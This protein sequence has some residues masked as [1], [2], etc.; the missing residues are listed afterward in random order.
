MSQTPSVHT[1]C[2]RALSLVIGRLRITAGVS[3]RGFSLTFTEAGTRT[4]TEYEVSV[5]P[6]EATKEMIAN[7]IRLNLIQNH[8]ASV[9]EGDALQYNLEKSRQSQ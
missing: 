1:D 2:N 8:S 9:E 4:I 7:L 5:P 3:L 6:N